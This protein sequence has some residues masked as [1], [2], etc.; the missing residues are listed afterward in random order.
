MTNA[1]REVYDNRQL[2]NGKPRNYQRFVRRVQFRKPGEMNPTRNGQRMKCQ[3]CNSTYHFQFDPQCK[4]NEKRTRDG[5]AAADMAAQLDDDL[6]DG[7]GYI[8]FNHE[9]LSSIIAASQEESK[10]TDDG[11]GVK[12]D[13]AFTGFVDTNDNPFQDKKQE[14]EVADSSDKDDK[15][16]KED[17]YLVWFSAGIKSDSDSDSITSANMADASDYSSAAEFNTWPEDHFGDSAS[18]IEPNIKSYAKSL[19]GFLPGW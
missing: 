5:T 13:D 16:D 11:N 12:F 7:M 15:E 18:N 1:Q 9:I 8:V 4:E 6:E 19:S 10:N 2:S 14:D 17:D 3:K